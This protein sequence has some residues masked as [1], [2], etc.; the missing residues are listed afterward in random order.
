MPL[1]IWPAPIT[2][3]VLM[4][5]AMFRSD[6]IRRR[7]RLGVASA[8]P[9]DVCTPFRRTLPPAARLCFTRSALDL[10]E[11]SRELRK[12]LVEVGDEPVIGDLEDRRLLVLVDRDDDFRVLHAG[13]IDRKS[14]RLNSSH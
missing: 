4:L 11:L 1:P 13:E 8:C 6:R 7:L 10:V 2:P 9:G 14:T 5:T 12:R 3:T